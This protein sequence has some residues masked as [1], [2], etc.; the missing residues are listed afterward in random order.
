VSLHRVL[1]YEHGLGKLLIGETLR[2]C[3]QHLSFPISQV[4][5]TGVDRP[6]RPSGEL[7]DQPLGHRW[8]EKGR[9]GGDGPDPV[10]ELLRWCPF[11]QK[12]GGTGLEGTEYILV[13]FEGGEDEHTGRLRGAGNNMSGRL[14]TVEHKHPY[15]HQHH[16]GTFSP[17][18]SHRLTTILRF[19]HDG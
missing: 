15:V 18:H 17:G 6:F 2:H 13:E 7:G 11:Q 5:Q 1:R 19:A 14:D 3:H 8:R 16:V 12:A 4:G 10:C 9:P